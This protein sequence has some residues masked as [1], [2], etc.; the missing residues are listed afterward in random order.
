MKADPKTLRE[1]RELS[2][3]LRKES[4]GLREFAVNELQRSR[5]ILRIARTNKARLDREHVTRRTKAAIPT[6]SGE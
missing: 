1:V 6:A 2:E 4:T 3:A 5:E